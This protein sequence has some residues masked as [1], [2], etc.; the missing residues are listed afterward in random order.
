MWT[1]DLDIRCSI[2]FFKFSF[3]CCE[4]NSIESACE[5]DQKLVN[6]FLPV[7]NKD[8][9]YVYAPCN[10]QKWSKLLFQ[11]PNND[12]PTSW[13]IYLTHYDACGHFLRCSRPDVKERRVAVQLRAH[14]TKLLLARIVPRCKMAFDALQ[15]QSNDPVQV[16]WIGSESIGNPIWHPIWTFQPN[17]EDAKKC[18]DIASNGCDTKRVALLQALKGFWQKKLASGE[19]NYG[20][21]E[22]KRL[23]PNN[24]SVTLME[25]AHHFNVYNRI[26]A[27]D[28]ACFL[29]S[30]APKSSPVEGYHDK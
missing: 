10:S 16:S 18:K 5:I 3:L 17:G 25:D 19:D 11:F 12:A 6:L 1:N 24:L 27:R 22:I 14:G 23:R 26:C 4:L 9:S 29:L 7:P 2:S 13:S 28:V 30:N 20:I 8:L 15:Q 21:R